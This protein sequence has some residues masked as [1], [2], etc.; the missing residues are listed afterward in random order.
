MST[1]ACDWNKHIFV[2]GA[3]FCRVCGSCRFCQSP[4]ESHVRSR[5][6]NVTAIRCPGVF[7]PLHEVAKLLHFGM[8]RMRQELEA[9][10]KRYEEPT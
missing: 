2:S 4:V 8:P 5:E 1:T 10:I 3:D 6:A 7:I 9:L